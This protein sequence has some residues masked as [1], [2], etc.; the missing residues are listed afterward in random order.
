MNKKT[1]KRIWI[2]VAVT[3]F[4]LLNGCRENEDIATAADN[5]SATEESSVQEIRQEAEPRIYEFLSQ[6]EIDQAQGLLAG[7]YQTLVQDV[8]ECGTIK[9]Y[10]IDG[11]RILMVAE[12]EYDFWYDWKWKILMDDIGWMYIQHKKSDDVKLYTNAGSKVMPGMVWY[13]VDEEVHAHAIF[14]QFIENEISVYDPGE[15]RDM[16]LVDYYEK[17]HYGKNDV[18]DEYWQIYGIHFMAEDLDGDEEEELLILLQEN[19]YGGDLFV[20]H[21]ADGELYAWQ[22]WD[23]FYDDRRFEITCYEDGLIRTF[24]PVGLWQGYYNSDGMLE[25]MTWYDRIERVES[26]NGDE[27]YKYGILNVYRDGMEVENIVKSLS[28]EGPDCSG[29]IYSTNEDI[30]EWTPENQSIKKECDEIVNEWRHLGEGEERRISAI[31]KEDE[32]GII[33]LK[34]LLR[35]ETIPEGEEGA[36]VYDGVY[37]LTLGMDLEEF[38]DYYGEEYIPSVSTPTQLIGTQRIDGTYYDW[39]AYDY[40][41]ISIWTTNYNR[42]TGDSSVYTICQINLWDSRFHT[43][44]G[45]TIGDTL[46]ELEA[47]YGRRAGKKTLRQTDEEGYESC[48]SYTEHGIVTTFYLNQDSIVRISIRLQ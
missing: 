42:K 40:E 3:S 46:E 29:V 19:A 24:G 7:N 37:T 47:A 28:Y 30:S 6:Q 27:W 26:E 23:H 35:M 41:D 48:Y 13:L 22:E 11:G 39:Y 34:D 38:R 4:F 14:D 17:Y 16:Y 31:Q 12:E 20:F 1:I 5:S 15:G 36:S 9:E 44:R 25:G 43:A 33:M 2:F 21:E 10:E 18:S 45:I 8:E 32:V